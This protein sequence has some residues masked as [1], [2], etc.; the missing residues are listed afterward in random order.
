[1]HNLMKI[2]WSMRRSHTTSQKHSKSLSSLK[3]ARCPFHGAEG[4]A[5][6]TKGAYRAR[7]EGRFEEKICPLRQQPARTLLVRLSDTFYLDIHGV[8]HG[9]LVA[10]FAAKWAR[11]ILCALWFK[12]ARVLTPRAPESIEQKQTHGPERCR[13]RSKSSEWSCLHPRTTIFS[14][15]RR[16]VNVGGNGGNKS[17]NT[18]SLSVTRDLTSGTR[19][20]SPERVQGIKDWMHRVSTF[21]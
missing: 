16:S 13:P 15:C 12:Y 11:A 2:T 18:K 3:Y 6:I 1:M 7:R 20:R 14:Q 10:G 17:R 21:S 19:P 9:P 5:E 8:A 4:T